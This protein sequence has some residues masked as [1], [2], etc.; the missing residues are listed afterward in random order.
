MPQ[1]PI[2]P[3]DEPGERDDAALLWGDKPPAAPRV[4]PDPA[5]AVE[6]GESYELGD[7]DPAPAASRSASAFPLPPDEATARPARR[8]AAGPR[9]AIDDDDDAVDEVYTRWAEWRPA[10]L[11]LVGLAVATLV[12][13]YFSLDLGSFAVTAGLLTLGLGIGLVL[14]YPILVTLEPPLRLT[15]EQ[16]MRDYYGA[17]EHYAPQ[18][19]RMWLLLSRGGRQSSRFASFE[20]FQRYWESRLAELRGPG[21]SA[22]T[23]LVFEIVEFQSEKSAGRD[24]VTARYTVRILARGS[25]AGGP[26]ATLPARTRLVRGPDR[27][28]YLGDGML[29]DAPAA[30]A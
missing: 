5:P 28:W 2:P 8:S 21:R 25:R 15:P 4:D 26:I 7:P 16:A 12:L 27:Q 9:E 24:D 29:P 14:S 30:S 10:I 18:Y 11:R 17:L 1:P 20:G 3:P 6:P 13:A 19:R 22:W 23:P